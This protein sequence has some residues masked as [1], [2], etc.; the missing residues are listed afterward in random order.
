M[1]NFRISRL[2]ED[3]KRELSIIFST[4]K[5]YRISSMISIVK[6]DLSNDLSSCKVYISSIN[7]FD[8]TKES[9]IGLMNAVGYIKRELSSKLE[10]RRI[11]DFKFIADNSIEYSSKINK[12]ID[13]IN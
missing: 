7:G 3:I 11:P 10:L 8:E 9:V 6:L 12:L 5:D 4:L 1:K 13:E 2:S